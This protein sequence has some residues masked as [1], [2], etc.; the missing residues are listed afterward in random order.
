MMMLTFAYFW[1]CC[2]KLRVLEKA[3]DAVFALATLRVVFA[4]QAD[5]A[6]HVASRFVQRAVETAL[7]R[8]LMTVAF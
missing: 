6:C 1:I 4:L 2:V 5:S 8:M 7:V 3:V